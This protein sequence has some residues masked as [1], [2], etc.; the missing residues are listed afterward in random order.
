MIFELYITFVVVA[1]FLMVMGFIWKEHSEFALVGSI[2]LFLLG[3]L[4]VQGSVTYKIGSNINSSLVYSA[5][6]DVDKI[7]QNIDYQYTPLVDSLS[8]KIGIYTA[9]AGAASFIIV[10]FSIRTAYT[11]KSSEDSYYEE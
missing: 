5:G 10:L 3:L 4:L 2:F 7:N 6:G 1:V 11:S 8:S 9:L